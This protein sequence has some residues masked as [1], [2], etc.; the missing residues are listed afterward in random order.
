MKQSMID[1]IGLVNKLQTIS[2]GK[3]LD[4]LEFSMIALR[5]SKILKLKH[6]KTK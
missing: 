2:G 6:N 1:E 5:Q 3:Q 4:H